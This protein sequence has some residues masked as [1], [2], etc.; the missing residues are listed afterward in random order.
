MGVI[1]ESTVP[2]PQHDRYPQTHVAFLASRF[3]LTTMSWLRE[4]L[5]SSTAQLGRGANIGAQ[6]TKCCP[7]PSCHLMEPWAPA[8][9]RAH[10]LLGPGPQA[11]PSADFFGDAP[12]QTSLQ[13]G[14][15]LISCDGRPYWISRR[16]HSARWPSI[17]PVAQA[18]VDPNGTGL[19]R[20][21]FSLAHLGPTFADFGPTPADIASHASHLGRLC[22]NSA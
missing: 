22:S 3:S 18:E 4:P 5:R 11:N 8:E 10:S 16:A 20:Q 21:R 6:T 12:E 13:R 1:A 19:G 7:N 14:G 9:Y 2:L 17:L 15:Q